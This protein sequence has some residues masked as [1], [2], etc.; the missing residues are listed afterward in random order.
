VWRIREEGENDACSRL[1]LDY[2]TS[3]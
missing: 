1:W 3:Q 2:A